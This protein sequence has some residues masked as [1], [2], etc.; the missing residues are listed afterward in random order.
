MGRYSGGGK[1]EA[2]GLKKINVFW[3]KKNGYLHGFGV[4]TIIWSYGNSENKSSVG[5]ESSTRTNKPYVRIHY[6]QTD[7][8]ETK[9]DYDYKILL[10]TTPCF[11]GGLRYWFVCPWYKNGVYCGRRVATLYLGGKHFA[12]RYCYDLTY[13]SRKTSGIW[14]AFGSSISMPDLDEQRTN[15]RVTHYAGK[16]T[17]RFQMW[18]KRFTRLTKQLE[19]VERGLHAVRRTIT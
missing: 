4:G 6:T 19:M 2:D 8:D 17:K 16:P 10:T 9:T 3:L 13:A 7:Y 5:I 18:A 11:F 15:M 1:D 14:K 12:C